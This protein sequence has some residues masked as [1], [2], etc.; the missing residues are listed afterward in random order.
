MHTPPE[1]DQMYTCGKCCETLNENDSQPMIIG[2]EPYCAECVQGDNDLF[3]R[4]IEEDKANVRQ[5]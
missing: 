4:L 2:G 1:A 3:D 5:A